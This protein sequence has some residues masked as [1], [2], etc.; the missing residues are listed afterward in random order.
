M[1]IAIGHDFLP[2]GPDLVPVLVLPSL[3]ER[4]SARKQD[5]AAQPP[6]EFVNVAAPEAARCRRNPV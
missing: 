1:W 6:H 2:A 5:V 3:A 4:R